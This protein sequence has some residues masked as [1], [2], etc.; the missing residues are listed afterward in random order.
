[1]DNKNMSKPNSF[2]AGGNDKEEKATRS[3]VLVTLKYWGQT[4]TNNF[5]I[6]LHIFP[7][8]FKFMQL[9]EFVN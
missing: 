3:Y 2:V 1:M 7:L 5:S 9:L 4:I 8:L 6:R